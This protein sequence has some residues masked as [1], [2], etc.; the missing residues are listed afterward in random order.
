MLKKKILMS[1][2]GIMIYKD[3]KMNLKKGQDVVFV[4]NIE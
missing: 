4:S 2:N 1:Q 3:L